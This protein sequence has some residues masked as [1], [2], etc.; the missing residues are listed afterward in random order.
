MASAA[1]GVVSPLTTKQ[2]TVKTV[3]LD[4]RAYCS[5]NRG[6]DVV[7]PWL[8]DELIQQRLVTLDE[9]LRAY[10]ADHVGTLFGNDPKRAI[11]VMHQDFTRFEDL[12]LELSERI[13]PLN[14]ELRRGCHPR[15]DFV[16][17]GEL[18]KARNWHPQAPN[19]AVSWYVDPG[20]TGYV[21]V[22]DNTLPDVAQ[23]LTQRLGEL[24]V[25]KLGKPSRLGQTPPH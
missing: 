6:A 1:V 8:N 22:V 24:V 3:T 11:V 4:T 14:V 2:V 10:E 18:L 16:A 25:V 23:A 5:E 12:Q 19:A 21:V 9:V 17:A 15:Q 20:F 7:S 13:A